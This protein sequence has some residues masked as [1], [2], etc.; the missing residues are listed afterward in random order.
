LLPS[1]FRTWTNKY[2]SEGG[3]G[4]QKILRLL[5]GSDD[6]DVDRRNFLKSIIVFWL[7]G[8]TDGHAK[9]FSI[10]L[11]PGG[12][13]RLTPLYDIVSAQP[14]LD[15][16]QI[17]RNK[18]KMAMTV[19]DTRHYTMESISGAFCSERR[20]GWAWQ[21]DSAGSDRRHCRRRSEG[22]GTCIAE[23]PKGF[24]EA[25]TKSIAKGVTSRLEQL[26]RGRE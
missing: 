1:P 20:E 4:V 24:P 6:A 13:Y 7:L 14:S 18:L 16:K 10:F 8:A 26:D 22:V 25:V 11:S 15:A 12:G 21:Q 5:A 17:G 2:E 3:P 19:G 23:L 9:N